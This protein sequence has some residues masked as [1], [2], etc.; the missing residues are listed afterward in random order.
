MVGTFD[1]VFVVKSESEYK[2]LADFITAAKAQPGKLN[3][4]T[5]AVG[6]TQ[7]LGGELFKSLGNLNVQIVPYKTSPDI[8]LALLRND[9]QIM[10]DFPPAVQ[11]QVADK[12][13]RI[14]A[15]S[16]PK[17]SPLFPGIPTVDA[18]GMKGYEVI[19]WNGVGVPKDTP[20][21]IIDTLNKAMHEVLAVPEL[22]EQFAKV[23]VIAQASTPGE[24]MDRLKS[25]IK[26]WDDVIV[27]AGIPK[28]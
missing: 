12:K 25:D 26:K 27:K 21:E 20:K 13:L 9:V 4:G 6:G 18:A 5:I 28:K 16:S 15:T 1:L 22:K 23:G 17:A 7:N 11:G 8:V 2:T 24:L 10:V 14:L 19:S 3:I